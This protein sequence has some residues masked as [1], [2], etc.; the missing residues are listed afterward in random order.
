MEG[1]CCVCCTNLAGCVGRQAVS[2]RQWACQVYSCSWVLR[3]AFQLQLHEC[4][5]CKGSELQSQVTP[6][7]PATTELS[8][9]QMHDRRGIISRKITSTACHGTCGA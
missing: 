6:A 5:S 4:A 1:F 2:G 7:L 8:P 9:Q 3:L